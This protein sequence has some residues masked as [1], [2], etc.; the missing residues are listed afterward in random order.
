MLTEEPGP[1]VR[2]RLVGGRPVI[3]VMRLTSRIQPK[4]RQRDV[5]VAMVVYT[6]LHNPFTT[7][8]QIARVLQRTP[9][10]A[11]EALD[12]A[13]RRVIDERP[14]ITAYKDAWVLSATVRRVVLS[15]TGDRSALRRQRVLWYVGPDTTDNAA[16]V[17]GWLTEHA[18]V[19]S[20][21]YAAL[22]GL[23]AAGAR[24]TLDRLVEDDLLIRGETAGRNAHCL[25]TT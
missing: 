23:T 15:S 24:K 4:A 9:S 5:Q 12:I 7:P 2:A 19:T 25:P 8:E 14:L 20:G 13:A 16:V 21:D 3:P 18:R 11:A 1:R 10:E 6:L 22:T 17:A